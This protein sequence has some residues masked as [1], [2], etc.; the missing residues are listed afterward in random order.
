MISRPRQRNDRVLAIAPSTRGFGFAVI[1]GNATLVDWGVTSVA[2]GNK[3]ADTLKKTEAM[4]DLYQPAVLVLEDASARGSRR[5]RRIRKLTKKIH[6][7][8]Q[9]HKITTVLLRRDQVMHTFFEDGQGTKH[10]IARILAMRFPDELG[11]RLPPK[12]KP[13]KSEDYRMGIFDALALAVA[14]RMQ[15][16]KRNSA[17]TTS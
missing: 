5:S 1:E 4:V 6:S 10:A 7:M 14:L 13:W 11:H 3:N 8:G 16:A 17:R 15:Q 12:R 2:S 9:A